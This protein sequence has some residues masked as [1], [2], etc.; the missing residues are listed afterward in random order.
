MIKKAIRY[1]MRMLKAKI[2][3]ILS[4]KKMQLRGV[5]VELTH[6]NISPELKHFFYNESYE[7]EEIGILSKH[8]SS[9][10]V[11]MEIGAGIGFLST[12]CAKQIG[13]DKVFAYEANP[14]MIEK[15]KETYKLNSV[16]P[17]IK[18]TLLSNK[19]ENIN[20]YL[21]KNFWSSSTVKRSEDAECVQVKSSD[22]NNEI[23]Q[24]K[25]TFLIVDIE[26]GEKD[27]IPMIDFKNNSIQKIII[28]IH[29]HVI[30]EYESSKIIESVISQ[31]FAIN[32]KESKGIVFMFERKN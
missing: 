2:R 15:I 26:G 27:L 3:K 19:E 8:L 32:F 10:D 25:P 31:G 9:H 4:V 23:S 21:E 20:F 7:S 12:Y 18:N 11:V 22:I 16:E 17:V 13:S 28:E 14:F 1:F 5:W 24:T 29:P 6:D 30:G